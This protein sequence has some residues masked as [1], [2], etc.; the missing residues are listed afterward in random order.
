MAVKEVLTIKT[1]TED[2]GTMTGKAMIM[3][4]HQ[5]IMIQTTMMITITVVMMTPLMVTDTLGQEAAILKR[6]KLPNL[7]HNH[8]DGMV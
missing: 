7:H 4:E 5:M 6:S 1:P 8:C 2:T 3:E